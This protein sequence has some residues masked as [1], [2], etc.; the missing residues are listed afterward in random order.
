MLSSYEVWIT[1]LDWLNCWLPLLSSCEDGIH[2]TVI[3]WLG[4]GIKINGLISGDEDD[5]AL[6]SGDEDVVALTGGD[7]DVVVMLYVA[8]LICKIKFEN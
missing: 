2:L 5:V 3:T 8:L 6:T 1:V 7:D 4:V